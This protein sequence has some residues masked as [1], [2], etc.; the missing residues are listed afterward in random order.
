MSAD[1]LAARRFLLPQSL[2]EGALRALAEAGRRGDEL[3]L[4]LTAVVE[5][6]Q[7]QSIRLIRA[8]APRQICHHTPQGL[9]VTI[10]GEALFELNRLCSEQ[11][12]VLVAQ[13]H[14]HPTDAYHSDAD[15]QLAFVR[16]PGGLS[17]VV[18]DF[19]KGPVDLD[20]WSVHQLGLDGIWQPLSGKTQLLLE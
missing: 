11:N 5:E 16:L 13:I 3:F 1:L 2:A 9:L 19:A 20:H 15:D 17:I 4:A 7:P 18:P 8:L 10:D 12:E 6:E 14:A